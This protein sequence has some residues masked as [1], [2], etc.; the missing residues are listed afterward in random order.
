MSEIQLLDFYAEWCGPCKQMNPLLEEI[1]EEWDDVEVVEYDV[2][3]NPPEARIYGVNS[4]P[5]YVIEKD[6]EIMEEFIGVTPKHELRSV[7]DKIKG[8]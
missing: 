3:E 2:D 7:I 6:G 4:V 5:T 1:D 8:E